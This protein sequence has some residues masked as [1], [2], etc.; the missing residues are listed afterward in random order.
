MKAPPANAAA[1]DRPFRLTTEPT[2]RKM[3]LQNEKLL[4]ETVE[5]ANPASA[6]AIDARAALKVKTLM[7]AQLLVMPIASAARGCARAISSAMPWGER[8]NCA[9]ARQTRPR[10]ASA[11]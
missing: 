7:R 8:R 3:P 11:R 1:S 9:S 5:E 2:R 10:I 6:P 4:G